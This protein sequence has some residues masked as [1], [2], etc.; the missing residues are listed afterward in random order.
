MVTLQVYYNSVKRFINSLVIK[1]NEISVQQDYQFYVKY[2]KTPPTQP[3]SKYYQNI[4]GMK[5]IL[6]PKVY[7]NQLQGSDLIELTD[8]LLNNNSNIRD[9]LLKFD[10]YYTDT[11]RLNPGMSDYIKGLLY[12]I[13]LDRAVVSKNYTILAYDMSLLESN[14]TYLIPELEAYISK[15]MVNYSNRGYMSDELYLPGLLGILYTSLFNYVLS[16]KLKNVLTNKADSFQRDLHL[17]SYKSLANDTDIL[18]LS[19]NI[20]LYGNINRMKHNVGGNHILHNVLFDVFNKEYIGIGKGVFKRNALEPIDRNYDKID[21]PYVSQATD[22]TIES[23]NPSAYNILGSNYDLADINSLFKLNSLVPEY[24]TISYEYYKSLLN[25]NYLSNTLTKMF[26]IDK[27]NKIKLTDESL[28]NILISNVISLISDGKISY[29]I[30]F[31]NPVDSMLYNLSGQQ[32]KLLL[33]YL[34]YKINKLTGDDFSI[35]YGAVFNNNIDRNETLLSTWYKLDNGDIFDYLVADVGSRDGINSKEALTKYIDGC[36]YIEKKVWYLISNLVDN[37]AKKDTILMTNYLFSSNIEEYN[38]TE[39][40]QALDD[41]GLTSFLNKF[42]YSVILEPLLNSIVDIETDSLKELLERYNKIINIFNKDT[43]YTVQLLMDIDFSDTKVINACKNNINLGYKAYLEIKDAEY[44]IYEEA[45][46]DVLNKTYT[47]DDR[48]SIN[49]S[50]NIL[51][52]KPFGPMPLFAREE[53]I[54]TSYD[55]F[56]SLSRNYPLYSPGLEHS[57]FTDLELKT[58]TNPLHTDVKNEGL[59]YTVGNNDG[60]NNGY[61]VTGRADIIQRKHSAQLTSAGINESTVS[62]TEDQVSLDIRQTSNTATVGDNSED[63]SGIIEII[64]TTK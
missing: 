47:I 21:L 22:L 19:T 28:F 16:L 45:D 54:N 55:V 25:D 61:D 2:D 62:S 3:H 40:E 34:L 32:V 4:A 64:A 23:A 63:V 39:I 30:D 24:K 15:V 52:T 8:E 35:K 6:D 38:I 13:K 14:E 49:T 5:N 11:I 53:T 1:I 31:Y 27:P 36:I 7:I 44:K 42:T 43:S 57:N 20:W 46:Y 12:N 17:V 29:G 50:L 41:Y 33:V 9:E 60:I 51:T 37:T 58:M 18:K 26:I 10:K 59:I 48:L 56:G